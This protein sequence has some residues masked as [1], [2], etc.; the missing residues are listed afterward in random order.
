MMEA[1]TGRWRPFIITAIFSGMRASELRGLTWDNV[2]LDA[3]I[4]HV[5]QSADAWRRM[6]PPKSRAG[7]R[8]IRW[9]RSL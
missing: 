3:G 1:A 5:R 2:D 4:I 6:G 7:S 9:H 8:D